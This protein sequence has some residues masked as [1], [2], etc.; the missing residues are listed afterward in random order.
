VKINPATLDHR[1]VHHLFMTILSPRP[2]AWVSTVDNHGINNLAPFSTYTLLSPHPPFVGFGVVRYRDGKK[3]DTLRNIELTKE[4][5][6]NVVTEDLAE[7]MN[8]TS[9]PYPPEVSEF[10]KVNL[11][12]VKSELVSP[13]RV[14][15]S[16][17]SL[18]CRLSQILEFGQEPFQNHFIIG[19]V[20]LIHVKEQFWDKGTVDPAKLKVIGRLGGTDLY[21]RISDTFEMKR[22][23]IKY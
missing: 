13:A 19:E 22:P 3:K 8:L 21:C 15:E 2:I 16:A 12:P 6:I 10:D 1:E 7:A 17:I 18:E 23:E 14:S 11:T 5:V 20:L 4:F 9:V